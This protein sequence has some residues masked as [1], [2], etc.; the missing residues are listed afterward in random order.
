MEVEMSSNFWRILIALVLAAHGIGHTYFLVYALGLDKR[1][2]ASRSWLLSGRVPGAVVMGVGIL[3]WLL[4]T[5]GF[6][7][8]GVGVFGQH[9]WWRGL[10]VVSSVISLLGLALFL[11]AKLPF[12]NAGAMDVIIL[13]ALLLLHWPSPALI[14]S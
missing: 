8:A 3:I 12:F 1:V 11:Q 14:G 5:V 6:V 10:A 7:V 4:A 2:Q 9:D 13:V